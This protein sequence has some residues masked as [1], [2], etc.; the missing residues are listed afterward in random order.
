M[1][2]K[3]LVGKTLPLLLV[4]S[5]STS[6]AYLNG[7][8]H[9]VK[10]GKVYRSAQLN[11]GPLEEVI[12]KY[13]IKTIINLRGEDADK[14]WYKDEVS[15]CE[16]H[17]VKHYNLRFSTKSLPKKESLLEL[18]EI[19]DNAEY[20]LI[21]HCKAGADRAGLA[22]TIYK[23]EYEGKSLDKA[24][25]QLSIRYG[26]VGAKSMDDF[27]KLYEEFGQGRDLRTWISEDYDETKYE[28]YFKHEPKLEENRY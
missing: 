17:G 11:N 22:G 3:K 9:A 8:I 5:M 23:L 24:L 28:K 12:R 14:E 2:I 19:F 7:N 18:F 6:C 25:K 1:G 10:E 20:P 26:H 4:A 27:F 21:F 16:K 15:I 13:E